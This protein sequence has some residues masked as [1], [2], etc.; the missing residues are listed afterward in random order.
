MNV[1]VL[2]DIVLTFLMLEV[3]VLKYI[4]QYDRG[5]CSAKVIVL[6]QTHTPP[7][8]GAGKLPP[9]QHFPFFPFLK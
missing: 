1:V 6:T 2:I 4:C 3:K 5:L 7:I 9:H 8:R